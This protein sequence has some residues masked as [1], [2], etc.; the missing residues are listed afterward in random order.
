MAKRKT[1]TLEHMP[2]LKSYFA[3]KLVEGGLEGLVAD[4]GQLEDA[5]E[6]L[7]QCLE[8]EDPQQLNQWFERYLSTPG[9]NTI[10]SAYRSIG[11]RS[12]N[13]LTDLLLRKAVAEQVMGWAESQGIDDL[14]EAVL[15][16]LATQQEV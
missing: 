12:K 8:Q 16:L 7:R 9:R 6:V 14:N 10:W 15:A 5:A 4:T 1:V 2:F 13:P 11:Y 3:K